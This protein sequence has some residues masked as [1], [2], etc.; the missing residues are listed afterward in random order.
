MR[1]RAISLVAFIF[2]ALTSLGQTSST[3]SKELHFNGGIVGG[4]TLA[5]VHGDGI[6]GFNKLGLHL[7]VTVQIH[8]NE[9]K[10]LHLG[11]IYNSKGSRKPQNPDAGDSNTWAY[12]FRYIDIPVLYST[13]IDIFQID[14]GLQP[15]VL[16]SAEENM[17]NISFDPTS[18]PVKDFD[19][20]AVLG[21][22]V[23]MNEHLRFYSRLT[24]SII[25]IT[26]L[27]DQ[28][29]PPGIWWDNRMRNMTL[30]FGLIALLFP[31]E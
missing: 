7:G 4:A 2:C 5:Q 28:D 14:I 27:P 24:Q 22:S 1:L 16:I 10:G 29:L 31:G 19:L 8:N 30:E 21:A 9:S 3:D 6:G 11:V 23:E 15:S 17:F 25:G 20:S 26:P 13:P 18:I 12:R